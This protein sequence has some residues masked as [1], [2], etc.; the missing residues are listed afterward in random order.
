MGI[1]AERSR[2]ASD[3][4]ASAT[5]SRSSW[6]A[7]V[8]LPRDDILA[9]RLSLLSAP[10]RPDLPG[11][12]TMVETTVARELRHSVPAVTVLSPAE[13]V[14]DELARLCVEAGA[15]PV[16]A[17]RGGGRLVDGGLWRLPSGV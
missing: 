10:L 5:L 4:E 9:L 14:G 15:R 2:P 3:A 16:G 6:R 11:W 13:L 17:L 7:G 1:G 12:T 8:V